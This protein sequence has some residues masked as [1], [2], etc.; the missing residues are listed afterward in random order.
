MLSSLASPPTTPTPV[1]QIADA[2]QHVGP[3]QGLAYEE[4]L[5]LAEHGEELVAEAGDVLFEEATPADRMVL[6]LKGE[7]HVQRQNSVPMALFIGRTG[8]MTGLLPFSRMTTFGGQGVAATDVWALMIPRSLFPDMLQAIPGMTQRVVSTLLDRVR[9]VT[10]IEQQA[11]KLAALGK[12]AGN[13]AHELNNPAS[14][15]QRAASSLVT[16]LRA[17]RSNRFKLVNLC[18]SEEQI[19]AVEAWE[20]T[21]FERAKMLGSNDAPAQIKREEELRSWLSALPC[22]NAWDVAP[23]LAEGGITLRDLE[24]LRNVLAPEGTCVTLQYFARYL[25]STR[26]VE[27]LLSSTDR[28]F[29]LISAI[30]AYSNMDRAAIS[31]VDVRAGLDATLLMFQSRMNG[32]QVER[33]YQA[34]LPCISA[35]AGELNQ[36]WTA[37]IENALDA[38]ET[39]DRGSVLRLTCRVEGDVLLT[40]IEDNGPGIPSELL[41]RIFEPFFTTKPPG[42]ALGLGL[43]NAM[44]IVRRHRGHLGVRS[45]PASTCFRVRLPLNQFEAY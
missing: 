4:R 2:L 12:L 13:L 36:V 30:K 21:I 19:H 18:L 25:R 23:D 41:D 1:E 43:D 38:M 40:Q 44:R 17:N 6:I 14:A 3:L 11:E 10:R 34:D 22:E 8:Q 27:T 5:W 7:I 45:E 31:E 29:D 39:V 9:E 42:H 37:L 32:V 35:Y 24:Q 20:R 26:S 28:I 16:E 15:A 33:D